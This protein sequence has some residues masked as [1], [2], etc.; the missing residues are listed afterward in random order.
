MLQQEGFM[1]C[2]VYILECSDGMYYTGIT[3]NLKKRLSEH[4]SGIK[5]A[6]QPSRRPVKIVYSEEFEARILAAKREKEIKGWNRHKKKIL[7][8]KFTLR[9]NSDEAGNSSVG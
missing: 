6:I 3:W 9:S 2:F 5:A 4:N 7:I 1:K 8:D